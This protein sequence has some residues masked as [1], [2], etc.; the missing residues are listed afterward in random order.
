[1]TEYSDEQI[2][3]LGWM[4]QKDREIAKK[5]E[6]VHSFDAEE[7][8]IARE[9][10]MEWAEKE[11]DISSNPS[12]EL[13]ELASTLTWVLSEIDKLTGPHR[14]VLPTDISNILDSTLQHAD[15]LVHVCND[16]AKT[17]KN[18]GE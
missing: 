4:V 11:A 5:Y 18:I 12:L 7:A 14:V 15:L 17:L 9:R 13:A 8:R 3:G 1:M 10:Q 6:S 16:I 2:A